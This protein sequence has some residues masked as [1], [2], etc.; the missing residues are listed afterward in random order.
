MFLGFHTLRTEGDNDA[1]MSLA[2]DMGTLLGG[3]HARSSVRGEIARAG[4]ATFEQVVL[5]MV[6]RPRIESRCVAGVCGSSMESMW[7]TAFDLT[8]TTHRATTR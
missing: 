3:L 6:V 8:H 1:V 2:A 5:G 7:L 4:G